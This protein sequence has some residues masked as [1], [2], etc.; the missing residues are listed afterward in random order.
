M[1]TLH[2][3]T[4]VALLALGQASDSELRPDA[5]IF[6][7]IDHYVESALRDAKTPVAEQASDANFVRRVTLDLVGRVPAAVEVEAYLSSQDPNKRSELV[8]R[9]IQ[10]EEFADYLAA[11][12]DWFITKGTGGIQGYLKNAFL[13]NRGWDQIFREILLADLL[14]KEE[15]VPYLKQRVKDSDQL[16]NEV[17]VTFFGVN[18]SCAK[19][20]DHPLVSDWTQDHF[21]GMKSF[22]DRTFENGGFVAERDYGLVNYK[23]T[24]GEDR[25]APLM[26]LTGKNVTL[27]ESLE[28]DDEERERLSKQYREL[29]KAKQPPP[30]PKLS[31]RSQL[32]DLAL[33]DGQN[34]FFARAIVNRIWYQLLGYG[35]VMPLDQMHSEN[36][37]SHPE[38]LEWL[39]TDLVA[40]GYDLRRLI[41]G[42]VLSQA[43]SRSS[44]W[45]GDE[46]PFEG[47]FAVAN[48]RPLT[49]TQLARSLSLV[50]ANQELLAGNCGLE[51]E[52]NIAVAA[53]A[54]LAELFEQPGEVFQATA[55]E[56]LLF[57]N[58]EKFEQ[59]YLQAGLMDQLRGLDS[60]AKVI[61]TAYRSIYSRPPT[62]EEITLLTAFID[63]RESRRESALRQVVWSLLA[64]SEFRFN[65]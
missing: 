39:A 5:P 37:A 18:I 36:P 1:S 7:A 13:A 52:Q 25:Q 41:R 44:E 46:R 60:T 33:A 20:H 23:T 62:G 58:G 56:A 26:F 65:H 14:S 43:Y 16:T 22:F 24:E 6:Q 50:T 55:N 21:Y 59:R 42:V 15:A 29:K 45:E 54:E 48:V 12:F 35:L 2:S 64:S 31:L 8:D 3:L 47:E 53:D 4:A 63:E 32:I 34:H 17:S 30:P 51:M 11:R 57:S 40:N 19:C 10:S 28:L 49:P 9:L 61:Q 27:D 38:L